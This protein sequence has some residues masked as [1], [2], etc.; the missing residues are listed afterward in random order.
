LGFSCEKLASKLKSYGLTDRSLEIANPY[1]NPPQ[2]VE[3]KTRPSNK[4][5]ELPPTRGPIKMMNDKNKLS[6]MV[7][8]QAL[9]HTASFNFILNVPP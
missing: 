6:T 3:D 1:G 7:Y 8:L 4:L 5:L 9:I 2:F